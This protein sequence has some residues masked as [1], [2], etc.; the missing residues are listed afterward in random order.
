MKR[1]RWLLILF[2]AEGLFAF[3]WTFITPSESRNAVLLGFSRER[4]L[5]LIFISMLGAAMMGAA[6]W[7][8]RSELHLEFIHKIFDRLCLEEKQLGSA[9]IHLIII[10]LAIITAALKVYLTP[11]EFDAY[12]NWAPDTFPFLYTLTRALLPLLLFV[13]LIGIELGTYLIIH[14]WRAVTKSE[15]WSIKIIGPSLAIMLITLITV[16]QWLIL[17]FQLRFFVNNPAW[18]WKFE[19]LPFTWR[20]LWFTLGVL[21]LSVVAYWILIIRHRIVLGLILIFLLGWF[22]QMGVGF[23]AGGGFASVQERYFSSYHKTYLVK[24][25]QNRLSILE[26]MQRYEELYGWRTFTNTKPPGLMAF[27]IGI[28]ELTNG[29]PPLYADNVRLERV[30]QI[31][32]YGF[33]VIAMLMVFLIYAFAKRFLQDG[34]GSIPTIIPFLYIFSPNIVLFSLFPDQAIYPLVFLI[35]VWFIVTAIQHQSFTWALLLGIFLYG[36]VFFSF[37]MLPLYLFAGIYLTLHYCSNRNARQLKKQ[38]M[39]AIGIGVGTLLLYFIFLAFLNYDFFSRFTRTVT[40]NHNFDFYLRVGRQPPGSPEPLSIRLQQIAAA[41]WVNNLDFAA[42]IGFPIYILFVIHGIRLLIRLFRG[43][44]TSSDTILVSFF[45]SFIALNLA[46]TA[47][48]ETARLW[49]FW[50]P[51]MVIFASY[52]AGRY[53]RKNSPALLWFFIMQFITILLTYHFQDLRM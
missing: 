15:T 19:L 3:F 10:P 18:Y 13:S 45:F 30:S 17:V 11:L 21:I 22:L 25:S 32:T 46:G 38:I 20:D 41:A 42:A 34:A 26:N 2:C 28:E 24:A 49:M 35:G 29:Y 4:I 6:I 36:A 50:I 5:L 31:V 14:Y 48:G 9:I 51:A 33:P 7:A 16:F 39:I 8:W 23:M 1:I 44:T 47:Q 37:T 52:E 27:Y 53:A 12:Q 40:I 43:E